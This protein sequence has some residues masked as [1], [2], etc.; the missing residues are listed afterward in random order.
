MLRVLVD[1]NCGAIK[2][3]Q[4]LNRNVVMLLRVHKLRLDGSLIYIFV[5]WSLLQQEIISRDKTSVRKNH[6]VCLWHCVI[7]GNVI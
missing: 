3:K 4:I 1:V 5:K 7:Q 2:L 6:D